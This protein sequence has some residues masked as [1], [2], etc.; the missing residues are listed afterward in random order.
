MKMITMAFSLCL[1]A[2]RPWPNQLNYLFERDN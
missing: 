1:W 2:L